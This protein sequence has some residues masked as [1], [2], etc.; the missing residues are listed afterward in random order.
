MSEKEEHEEIKMIYE[1][2]T[3]NRK[4]AEELALSY[5]LKNSN[6][7]DD[8]VREKNAF[9]RDHQIIL[10]DILRKFIH[11]KSVVRTS[12]AEIEPFI[13]DLDKHKKPANTIAQNSALNIENIVL[14]Q[15]FMTLKVIQVLIKSLSIDLFSFPLI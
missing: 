4:H 11:E 2:A 14:I 3:D 1:R 6:H 7:F 13:I 9:S 12:I 15:D 8:T 10:E 5:L